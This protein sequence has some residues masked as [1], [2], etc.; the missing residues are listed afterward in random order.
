VIPLITE[1]TAR[2]LN[3]RRI[4]VEVVRSAVDKYIY[5]LGSSDR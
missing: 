5:V 2:L 3:G 1:D 4:I